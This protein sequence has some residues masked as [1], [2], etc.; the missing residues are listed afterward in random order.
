MVYPSMLP[1]RLGGRGTHIPPVLAVPQERL[2]S[3]CSVPGAQNLSV[4]QDCVFCTWNEPQCPPSCA[5]LLGRGMGFCPPWDWEMKWEWGFPALSRLPTGPQGQ[6]GLAENA[7]IPSSAA[8]PSSLPGS[9]V[10]CVAC[11]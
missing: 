7:W 2:A 1:E 6:A 9:A 5:G 11:P 8:W 4:L 3:P 10:R